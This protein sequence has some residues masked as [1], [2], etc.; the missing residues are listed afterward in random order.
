MIVGP[1]FQNQTHRTEVRLLWGFYVTVHSYSFRC[2]RND[3]FI[4][5]NLYMVNRSKSK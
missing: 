5:E 1:S 4:S 2:A 3:T